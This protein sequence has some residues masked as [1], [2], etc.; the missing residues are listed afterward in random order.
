MLSYRPCAESGLTPSSNVFGAIYSR[1]PGDIG[2]SDRESLWGGFFRC[3]MLA[4]GCRRSVSLMTPLS[5]S[6][7]CKF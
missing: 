7:D 1:V 3:N 6:R 4:V 2:L 5:K